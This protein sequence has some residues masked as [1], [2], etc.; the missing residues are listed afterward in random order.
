MSINIEQWIEEKQY[1]DPEG[2]PAYTINVEDLRE[3]LKTHALVP[4][5]PANEQLNAMASNDGFFGGYKNNPDIM[6]YYKQ[7]YQSI[8]KAVEAIEE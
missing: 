3:L 4:R 7:Q 8:I 6:D 1:Y 2:F 5:E